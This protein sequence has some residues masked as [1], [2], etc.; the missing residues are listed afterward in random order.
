MLDESISILSS[1]FPPVNSPV[2]TERTMA[3][4]DDLMRK[5]RKLLHKSRRSNQCKT[6]PIAKPP[7]RTIAINHASPKMTIIVQDVHADVR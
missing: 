7:Y 2:G 3:I 1:R 4:R 5:G 6:W